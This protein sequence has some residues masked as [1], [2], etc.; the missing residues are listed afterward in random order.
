MR[1]AKHWHRFLRE[2][3]KSQSLDMF[4]NPSGHHSGQPALA[5]LFEHVVWIR[6]PRQALSNLNL[7]L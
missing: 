5:E 2:V 4:K 6:C 3:G 1:V 7:I